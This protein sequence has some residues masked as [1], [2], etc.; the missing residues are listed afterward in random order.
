[1]PLASGLLTGKYQPGASFPANDWR[2]TL[3]AAKM[4]QDLAEVEGIRQTEL[5]AG[6]PLAQWA[7]AWCLKDPVVTAVIP[8]CKDPAQVRANASAAEL[9]PEP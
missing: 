8:G 9:V 3:D 5:P 4:R 1:M 6:V 7:L 2:S